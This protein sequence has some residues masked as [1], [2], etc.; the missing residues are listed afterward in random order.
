MLSTL[1]SKVIL[2]FLQERLCKNITMSEKTLLVFERKNDYERIVQSLKSSFNLVFPRPVLCQ[3][4]SPRTSLGAPIRQRWRGQ[5]DQQQGAHL[6]GEIA[7]K[8]PEVFFKWKQFC[9]YFRIDLKK[10]CWS[11]TTGS[12]F[13]QKKVWNMMEGIRKN[14]NRSKVIGSNID[15]LKMDWKR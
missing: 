13:W 3:G 10:T 12:S 15:H 14:S 9:V 5:G 11:H 7:S 6:K 1:L 8:L 4:E 2:T